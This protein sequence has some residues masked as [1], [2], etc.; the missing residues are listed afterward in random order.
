M[1]YATTTTANTLESLQI[2]LGPGGNTFNVRSVAVGATKLQSGSGSDTINIGSVVAATHPTNTAKIQDV[3]GNLTVDGQRGADTLNVDNSGDTANEVGTFS[4]TEISGL[5][6]A[7][8]I[9]YQQIENLLLWLGSGNDKL[10]V[11]STDTQTTTIDTGSETIAPSISPTN[12]AGPDL[13]N[14]VVNVNSAQGNTTIKLGGGNDVV[15]V[16]YDQ[17]GNQTSKSGVTGTFTL[18]GN[19]GAD[20][21]EIGVAGNASAV[22]NVRDDHPSAIQTSTSS[23]STA[24]TCRIISCSGRMRSSPFKWTPIVFRCRTAGWSGSITRVISGNSMS[25]AGKATTSLSSMTIAPTRPSMAM[26]GTTRSRSGNC[27]SLRAAA[28]R[29]S[30]TEDQ[31]DTVLTTQGYLSN[32]V[33]YPA[34]IFGGV[35]NDTF[36]VYHNLKPL[37]LF[38]EEDNDT[39]VVRAF[40]RVDPKDPKAPFTNINGGQGADFISYTINS[41]V[42]VEGGDGFDTLTV[43][44][45]EFGDDFVVTSTGI[46]GGGLFVTFNGI[47]QVVV[48]ALE[49]NDNFY[50][51][52]TS[53]NVD[54]KL[55]VGWAA[56]PLTWPAGTMAVRS[57]STATAILATAA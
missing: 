10:Y 1:T 47:E 4:D 17:N 32:G 25:M 33:S 27:S 52:S 41:P 2:N 6:M 36:T 11:A 44:G 14:D 20:L 19:A 26:R 15:R 21:Y 56:T 38:G 30:Q 40:V 39:F 3:A 23:K 51:D 12:P 29:A 16:N 50:I 8:K 13:F 42:A 48:D 9:D 5:G 53:P 54:V 45:T 18:N 7:G 22:I 55:V 28:T 57:A 46:Y 49:G 43:V 35:G 24:P 31:F 34:T 37:N